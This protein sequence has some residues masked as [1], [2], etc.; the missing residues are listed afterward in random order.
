M[1]S[2]YGIQQS[3][4]LPVQ[5]VRLARGLQARARGR[6]LWPCAA[7]LLVALLELFQKRPGRL[8][9]SLRSPLRSPLCLAGLFSG[10]VLVHRFVEVAEVDFLVASRRGRGRGIGWAAIHTQVV[11]IT[12]PINVSTV[13]T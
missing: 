13:R 5:N 7:G 11:A 8:P 9:H 4:R 1:K 12:A 10:V 3:N 2:L 6:W